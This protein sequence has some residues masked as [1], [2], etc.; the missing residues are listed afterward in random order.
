MSAY[1]MINFK[2]NNNED[3]MKAAEIM[4]EVVSSRSIESEQQRK[5][6]IS[7]IKVEDSEV[8]AN[9]YSF[10]SNTFCEIVPQIMM[11]IARYNFGAAKMFAGHY[12]ESCGYEAEFEGRIFKNGKFRM[13]FHEHE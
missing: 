3:V 6:F 5:S 9:G 4:R 10:L 7:C 12:S 11:E 2:M 1:T 13:R 8:T